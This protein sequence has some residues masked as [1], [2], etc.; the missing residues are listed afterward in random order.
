MDETNYKNSEAHDL[1]YTLFHANPI[2]TSLSRME[3][4]VLVDVNEA[5]LNYFGYQREDVLG[6]KDQRLSQILEQD[7]F[8]ELIT[9]IQEK[10]NIHNFEMEVN[11]SS[12][13]ARSVL[14][15]VQRVEIEEKEALVSS[16][17]DITA[18]VRAERKN[19]APA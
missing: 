15:S 14:V 8:P 6:Q 18:R 10:N 11:R 2:P 13:E 1:F 5:Y 12:G 4:G 7:N 19:Q 16:F 3:D 17:I 9:Q